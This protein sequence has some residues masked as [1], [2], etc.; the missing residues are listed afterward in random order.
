MTKPNGQA[1]QIVQRKDKIAKRGMTFHMP[2]VPRIH[3]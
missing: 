3:F 1:K 2:R